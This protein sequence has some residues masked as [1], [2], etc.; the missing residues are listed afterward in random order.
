VPT[1]VPTNTSTSLPASTALPT[2][3]VV[4][5]ETQDVAATQQTSDM[6][7]RIQKYVQAGYLTSDKGNFTALVDS[8]S[9]LAKKNYL[10]VKDAG[11]EDKT[12]DFAVWS[13]VKLSSAA[14]VNYPEYSG[15]GFIF[16]LADNGDSYRA[17]VTKDRVLMAMCRNLHCTEVGKTKGSGRLSYDNDFEADVELIVNDMSAHVLVDGQSIGDYSLSSTYLTDPGFVGYTVISGTNKDYGTR[18][19]FSN[20]GLW[21]PEQ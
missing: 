13:H 2:D 15:C 14:S 1:A 5:T 3:T 9:E 21:T 8:S 10:S 12:R 18:C 19:E 4:P 7:S 16:R 20:G 17:M 11:F 6:Q